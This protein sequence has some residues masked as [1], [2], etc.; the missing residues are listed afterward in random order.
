M[1]QAIIAKVDK[2]IEIPG[3]NTI[4][5]AKVLGED[6]IVG[7]DITEGFVGIFFPVDLQLSEAYCHENSLYRHSQ[8]NKD[9]CKKGFFED[10]RR[11]RAQ[12]FMKV[13]SCGYFAPLESLDYTGATHWQ[14]GQTFDTVNGVKICEK[15]ISEEVKKKMA[16]S[17]TKAK[18][19]AAYPTFEKHVDSEQF[20][21]YAERIPT[22]SLIYFHNKLHGTSFRVAMKKESLAL[23]KWKQWL[24]KVAPIFSDQTDFK[25]V[26]GTRNVVIENQEKDGYHGSEAF[27]FEVADVLKPYLEPGMQ[28][29]GEIVG[30]AN[31]KTI[32]PNHDIRLL[33]EKKFTQKYGDTNTYAYGCKE[34]QYRF[35][36]YRITRETVDG[37]NVDLSQIELEEWCDNRDLNRTYDV[38]APIIYDGDVETLRNIVEALTEREINLGEDPQFP[39]MVGEGV[40]LRVES[41]KSRPDFYKSKSFPFKV[42][43]GLCETEDMETS[44]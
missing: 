42:M 33:K 19:I 4:Q 1:H 37:K 11:V 41:G 28:V 17:S 38:R 10:S 40:I 36:I 25:L 2:I 7:K 15:Y 27:R 16:N 44:S 43:E 21:H 31:G 29:F 24:N 32:M 13:K 6:V 26:V 23:P 14:L 20:K 18:K 39:G 22:G 8:N 3:A 35:H 12:P 9:V 5:I 34:H 30:Y